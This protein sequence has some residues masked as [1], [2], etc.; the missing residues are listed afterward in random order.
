[1]AT[2]IDTVV[3]DDTG[4]ARL[5]FAIIITFGFGLG[6]LLAWPV[7]FLAPVLAAAFLRMP[8]P[9]GMSAAI[10][11]IG[12]AAGILLM[13]MAI[14]YLA[15]PYP[16]L[17]V[18]VIVA[19]LVLT[20]RLSAAGGSA[21]TVVLLLVAL[22]I[23][24][25]VGQTS[26]EIANLIAGG[27]LFNLALAI[28]LS[29]LGFAILP[30]TAAPKPAKA[31][32]EP[33]APIDADTA[34]LKMTLVVAPIALAYLAFGWSMVL[35]LLFSALLAQQLSAASGIQATKGILIANMTGAAVAII[36][37]F[38]L[39]AVPS[40]PF[41]AALVFAMAL[42]VS[43]PAFA[44][45]P[46]SD[47]WASAFG[48]VLVIL[49]GSL[50]PFG[51]DANLKAIDRIAQI[52]LAG[53]YIV[54]AYAIVETLSRDLRARRLLLHRLRVWLAHAR[55]MLANAPDLYSRV[56]AYLARSG[57][58]LE[59]TKSF[60]ARPR[61]SLARVVWS[62]KKTKAADRTGFPPTDRT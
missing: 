20:F 30:V 22:L 53:I 50:A 61:T 10:K 56:K 47:L 27:F 11:L 23:L 57:V 42:L 58:S 7:A 15:L 29:W 19:G 36:A 26:P 24:P 60:A 17:A 45:G 33:G 9:M 12:G 48:A 51:D 55:E 18:I 38:L 6:Q 41:M 16:L 35:T 40:I 5:R 13:G 43:G 49:G 1:M 8:A 2:D 39:V 4:R 32:A 31:Q 52:A 34:A 54:G 28:L 21:L 3:G 46:A 14:V 25:L 62:W 44:G 37:Y 59:S